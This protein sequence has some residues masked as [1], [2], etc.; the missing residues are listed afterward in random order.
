MTND[1]R[2][3]P[4]CG[5]MPRQVGAFGARSRQFRSVGFPLGA[6][7]GLLGRVES[8]EDHEQATNEGKS[9]HE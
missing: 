3:R 4:G 5:W 1:A 9:I 6:S 8:A 7:Y 2:A